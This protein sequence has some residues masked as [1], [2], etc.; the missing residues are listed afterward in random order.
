[1]IKGLKVLNINKFF[2]S[3][4]CFYECYNKK[5]IKKINFVQDNI[6]FSKKNVLRGIHYQSINPQGKLIH[7]IKGSIIDIAVDLRKNSKSFGKY[8]SI[9]L[10][11]KNSKALWIPRGFGHAYLALE[12]TIINYKVDNFWHKKSDLTINFNDPDI[13]IKLP[14][15]KYII[16]KK[17]KNG[18]SLKDFFAKYGK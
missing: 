8:F 4:G 18:I 6:A 3:R 12:E 1:M 14:K 5:K 10:S 16:S 2:D 9:I 7:V 11:Q 13:N 15:K 17:D